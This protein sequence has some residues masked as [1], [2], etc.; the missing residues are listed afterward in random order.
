MPWNNWL[1]VGRIIL[2]LTNAKIVFAGETLG[3]VARSDTL[4]FFTRMTT[5]L[6][7]SAVA[8]WTGAFDSMVNGTT[9]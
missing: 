9:K 2:R 3:T 8:R 4:I 5:D 6:G 7:V 1:L